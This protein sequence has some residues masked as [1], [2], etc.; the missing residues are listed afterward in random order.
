L[1]ANAV[2]SKTR[3]IYVAAYQNGLY[4]SD[5]GGN[6]WLDLSAGFQNFNDSKK[7]NRLVLNP[8]QSKSLF[9]V[10]K[11]GIL[12]TDDD[13]QTWKELK[14]LT[15]PGSV[16]IFSFAVNPKNDKE[17]YYTGTVLDAKKKNLKST[18]Y[19]SMDGGSSWVTKRLPADTIPV[20][21][22]VQPVNTKMLFLGFTQ[23]EN[24]QSSGKDQFGL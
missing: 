22:D 1:I 21:L 20:S 4:R 19:K 3:K 12:R 9:W 15:P 2:D 5:D 10:S 6:N 18:F 17:L 16:D 24:T 14:L 13:G 8:S 23:L 11:Y 7:F